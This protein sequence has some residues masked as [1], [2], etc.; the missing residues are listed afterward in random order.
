MK[1]SVE[2]SW[3]HHI[4]GIILCFLILNVFVHHAAHAQ[5]RLLNVVYPSASEEQ[6]CMLID[7]QGL[8]WIGSDA[9]LKSY[10]GYR[11]K[12]YRSSVS[13]PNILPS[14]TILC[15]TEGHDDVIWIGTRNGLV[16][17]NKKTGTFVTH[18]LSGVG[19][20]VIYALFTSHD[21]KIWIGTDAGITCYNP[22]K[23]SFF[24]YTSENTTI[25]EANGKKH[26]MQSPIPVKSFTEDNKG[27][28]Y[29]GAWLTSLYRLDTQ[30]NTLY[31]YNVGD[32]GRTY[33]L[34]VDHA[35]KLWVCN[36]GTG[37]KCIPQPLSSQTPD[38]ID[39]YDGNNEFSIHY[40]MIEDRVSHTFWLSSR[41][42]FGVID[43]KNMRAGISYY[44]TFDN[45]QITNVTDVQ[46]DD[47]GNVW[48]LTRNNGLY[49]F[50]TKPSL[51]HVSSVIP[52]EAEAN[53]ICSVFTDDGKHVWLTLSPSGIA[54]Y[55][56]SKRTT[57]LN[58]DIPAVADIPDNAASTHYSGILGNGKGGL[59]LA[60]NGFGITEIND[61]KAKIIDETNSGIVKDRYVN[62]LYRSRRG[63]VFVGERSHLNYMLPSGKSYSCMLGA[64]VRGITEDYRGNIWVATENKGI[65]RVS[66]NFM[67]PKSLHI[68]Y[69]NAAHGNFIINE[70]TSCLED[71]KHRLWA[72]S[73]VGGL[74]RYNDKKDCFES[75]NKEFHWDVDCIFSIIED[76]KGCLWLTTEDAII[77]LLVDEQ[78][79][80]QYTMYTQEDGLGKL[81]FL[82]QSCFK[83][84][85]NL[86]FGTGRNLI[87]FSA[88]QL[89]AC[90][91]HRQTANV[92]ITDLM[93]DGMKY[94]E[95]DSTLR[96][97]L[98]GVTPQYMHKLTLPPSIHKFAIE[99]ALL[100]YTNAA[101]CKY[102]YYLE[103]YD[104][105]WHYV[106][107]DL[108]QAI[109][110]N[111]PSGS[112]KLHL[113]AAGSDGIWKEMPYTIHVKVLPPWYASWMA[114]LMYICLFIVAIKVVMI[115]YRKHLHTKNRL[116][117]DVVFTNI[118]H[119]LLTPLT[120]ISAAAES[121]KRLSPA[122]IGQTDIIQDNI[123][124]LTRMLRQILEV[125]KSQ[126]GKLQLKVAEN[127][128]GA[129]CKGIIHSLMPMFTA[130]QIQYDETIACLNE[131]AWFDTDKVETILYNLLNNAVKYTE[132]GGKV[133]FRVRIENG[134]AIFM[135][136]DT[137]IGISKDKM[138]HLYS[139]FLDGDYRL[140]NNIGTGIGLSLVNDLVKL[141]HGR[142]ECKSKEN[143]G[144]IFTIS[145]PIRKEA[146][147]DSEILQGETQAHIEN[148]MV[149]S[150]KCEGAMDT[151]RKNDVGV[152]DK[153]RDNPEMMGDDEDVYNILLVE[154]N[155]ELLSL[156]SRLLSTHYRVLTAENGEKAQKIIRKEPLDV[157]ITDVMMPVMDG[158]ELTGWIK[159]NENFSQLPV[160]M[161]TAKTQE[162]DC[163]E[164]YKVGADAYLAKPFRLEDLVLRIDNIIANR[165]RIRQKFQAQTDTNLEEQHYSSPDELFVQ[166]CIEKIKEHLGDCNY[167]REQLAADLCISSS[168]L[169]N[170]LRAL[171]GLNISGFITSIRMKEA[172]QI[173]KREP[174]IRVNELAYRVGF[175]TPGY[176]SLCFKKEYGMGIREYVEQKMNK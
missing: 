69:Y 88:S 72:I 55:D 6:L 147:S 63:I 15:M 51:F 175:S 102:A 91:K 1:H 61:G 89:R 77:C 110:E 17:M 111:L 80:A 109:F 151:R 31:A 22:N 123:R 73:K 37:V 62:T 94:S 4:R 11:F 84:G 48:L 35:G 54:L 162:K 33:K 104:K 138:K 130:K 140:V 43:A 146:Y 70:A 59:W 93:I 18:N 106:D 134:N 139:R 2:V 28:I 122:T 52:S 172:C 153:E 67:N 81:V 13:T 150:L 173:L 9:G 116:Q 154:D 168:T 165:E 100:T 85:D 16:S 156:M 12:T 29:I 83:Y 5:L 24:Y 8:I 46:T 148:T 90:N 21:G 96:Y 50:N 14:N 86:Y 161:L 10:D 160:V 79:H 76:N 34:K 163:S 49:H 149:N 125:R 26:Q 120:V 19:N 74:F 58:A 3:K 112:Y 44:K 42:G 95:L 157:V 113:K 25:V 155:S 171:T 41:N 103:G 97:E 141:H 98:C 40:N 45:H 145:L 101:Q 64:D 107:A 167:G 39:L 32:K 170:R 142:I 23:K 108:R 53:R 92:I 127:N 121:I 78:G 137:G 38:I 87:S 128:L 135:V 144:T 66:G 164:G 99:F 136:S 158:M 114:Y 75:V 71:S 124:R 143:E 36:W 7:K 27:N 82:N 126:A 129:F 117:M 119:E 159:N 57:W 176:F 20:R 56:L 152:F 60:N 115:G 30:T 174:S 166:N 47:K 132:S 118:T 105:D 65:M 131:M 133:T 169:Y 68:Q